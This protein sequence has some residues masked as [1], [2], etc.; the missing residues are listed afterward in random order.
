MSHFWI[1]GVLC[2]ELLS[3]TTCTS[4]SAGTSRSSVCKNCLN[5]IARWRLCKRPI[6]LPVVMSSAAERLEVPERL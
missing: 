6:T 4:S 5:S 3:S 1:A 2:V